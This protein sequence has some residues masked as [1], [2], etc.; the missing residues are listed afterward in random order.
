LFIVVKLV[1][2]SWFD[3]PLKLLSCDVGLEKELG[4]LK[5]VAQYVMDL[6]I[7]QEEGLNPSR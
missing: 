5:D 2:V 7:P 3:V 6:Y 1:G 4:E